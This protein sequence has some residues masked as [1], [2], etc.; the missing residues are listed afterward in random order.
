MNQRIF[1]K[2]TFLLSALIL[3]TFSP[4]A[5]ASEAIPRARYLAYARA[6]ADW[7]YAHSADVLTQWK[8]TFDPLNVFGYRPPGGFLETAVIYSYLYEKEKKPEY[9]D[10]A[11]A[12]LLS[13]G[14]CRSAYPESSVKLRPDYAEG[15]PALPDF[16][17]GMRYIRAYD[18]LRRLG[19]FSP[20]EK[21]KAEGLIAESMR[22]LLRTQEWGPMNRSALRAESLAWAVRALPDYPETPK[23]EMQRQAL[24]NDNW[25]HW[26]IEDATIYNG[27]W[28]Y[29]ILGYADA[30]GKMDD[31]FKTPEISYY[32]QYYTHLMSPAGMIPDFGDAHWMSNWTHFLVFFEAA[33]ARLKAPALK[34]A[35]DTIAA[36]FVDFASPA[37]VGL[38]A[39]LLDCYRWGTDDVR[40]APPSELSGEVMEDIV[41]K[42][43]VFRDG[44]TP[45]S[46]Y[47]LLNYRDE[48]DGGLN[49]RDYLRDSIPVEEEKTTHGHADENSLVL[50]MSGG[51]VLLHDAGYRDYMP[52]GPFGAYRQD[53]FH[54]R[55]CVRPEK[56]WM[57][58]KQG[59]YRYSIRD[60]VPGQDLLGFLRDAGSYRRT[61]TQK[62]DFL[63]FPDFDYSRTRVTDDN[64]GYQ[65]DRVVVYVK[66]PGC[67]V[68]FDIFK[69]L[70]EEYF[71][72]AGLWHTQKIFARG[73]HWYDTGYERIQSSELGTDRRLLIAFPSPQAVIEGTEPER[74]HYQD[75][76]LIH[77]TRAQHFE[78]GG[79]AV[80]VSVLVPHG[81]ADDPRPWLE[82]ISLAPAGPEG[83]A[84]GVRIRS[85]ERDVWIGV[86]TDLRMDISRDMRRP[87]YTYDAGRI[88]VGEIE[89]NGD[90]LFASKEEGRLRYTI[91]NL[92]K[93]LF[94]GSPL[95]EVKDS[96]YGLAFDASPDQAGTGKLRYWRDEA[97]IKR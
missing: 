89:T 80:L 52:S 86:K 16:F 38:G 94:K 83:K 73:E 9:A 3:M 4:P 47:L 56:V 43:I 64:W 95:V 72:L 81:A 29:S 50:L 78:L 35:A 51:S 7:A 14:D 22:Y 40:P 90:F 20:E 24:G 84:V 76:W 91:V 15:V 48:G 44:W 70:R 1:I 32:A 17:T 53:Y 37:N 45:R 31:L 79:T 2:A 71:T 21:M 41:G 8:K 11:K 5:G 54:N 34:W 65:S 18:T 58:Q 13:Y 30:M 55:L 97:V 10:R 28:L 25:G 49:Y 67:F 42:K 92:T 36:R 75:E 96:L 74:R 57:G 62:V 66:D 6:S 12:I 68:V 23:W 39:M 26:E 69:A 61:R 33:A 27:V 60:A 59:E 77:Q 88:R 82:R 63:T 46:T 85:G 87:R 93:A 19:R